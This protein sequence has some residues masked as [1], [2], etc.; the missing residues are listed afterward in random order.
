VFFELNEFLLAPP[1]LVEAVVQE[2][3]LEL[4]NELQVFRAIMR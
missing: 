3:S 1:N 2:D 4:M